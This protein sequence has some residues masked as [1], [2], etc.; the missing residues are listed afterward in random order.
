M[1]DVSMP[2]AYAPEHWLAW[3][4]AA[5]AI[6]LATLGVLQGFDVIDFR[7][8]EGLG[9]QAGDGGAAQ[10]FQDGALLL[11]PA[12]ISSLLALTLH[13]VEHHR[14]SMNREERAGGVRGA[15]GREYGVS[16]G[17][18]ALWNLEHGLA[19]I[20]GL[21]T[22]VWG[23]LT[24]LV[25]FDVFDNGN[26]WRDGLTWGILGIVS[27]LLTHTLH[28]VSHHMPAVAAEEAEIRM[29]VEERVGQAFQRGRLHHESAGAGLTKP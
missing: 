3:L 2:R 27:G 5:G 21:A 13:Q 15:E 18:A 29:I 7:S 8:G 1:R 20:G 11:V 22:V 9:V 10:N 28:S 6:A 19:Y 12:I 16:R 23:A 26:D 17:E 24:I 4:F 25:G 14:V